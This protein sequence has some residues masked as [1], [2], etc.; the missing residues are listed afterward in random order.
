MARVEALERQRF[1]DGRYA[2]VPEQHRHDPVDA[3]LNFPR[4]LE[5][6][7][8]K[9]GVQV[10]V[11]ARHQVVGR[12]DAA[13][14][15]HGQAADQHLVGAVDHVDVAAVQLGDAVHIVVIGHRVFHAHNA[16]DFDG[17][18]HKIHGIA[19]QK[20]GAV[21]QHGQGACVGQTLIVVQNLIVRVGRDI[22]GHHGGYGVAADLARM[23][24]Q[25]QRRE[26]V[27]CAH[28]IDHNAAP[29]IDRHGQ[30]GQ[31]A[32]RLFGQK[33]PLAGVAVDVKAL[34]ALAQLVFHDPL[35]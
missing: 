11:A 26:R 35:R 34:R 5:L 17:L 14:R 8:H 22:V 25:P 32:A 33:Q 12:A 15:A 24:R 29:P 6:A 1:L 2:A 27:H 7:G 10:A 21:D 9:R 3:E 31:L 13:V 23:A 4:L 20:A 16:V 30:L 18:F 28:M 19:L